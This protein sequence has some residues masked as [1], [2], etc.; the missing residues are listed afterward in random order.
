MHTTQPFSTTCTDGVTLH[1]LLLLPD[2]PK[3]VVQFNGGTATKK[4]F[5]LPF[6]EYLAGH[7]YVCC[8]WDYRG[9]GDSAPP[10]LSRCDYTFR[11]YGLQDMPAIK[12]FLRNIFP[13]L[14]L[15]LFG[16]SV[17][18]QQVGFMT[19]LE[20]IQGMVCFAVSTGYLPH[21]PLPYRLQAFYFFYLFSPISI[22]LAGYVKAKP[23][24]YMENL[25]RRVVLE[26]RDWCAKTQYLFDP[27]FY[28]RT[29]PEGNFNYTFPVHI[30][31][32]SDDPIA[33]ERSV[34][35]FWNNVSSDRGIGI[36]KLQPADFDEK[37][38][39]HFGFFKKRMAAN[40]WQMAL[41]QLD[42]FL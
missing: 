22:L 12:A 2:Q 34:P 6:L 25:P 30:F 38:I 8:L 5:Y 42:S 9:S 15:L 16:H 36:T 14:P 33:N 24:G 28:G 20:D 35:T 18:G 3:A 39:G 41:Q 27:K 1:G 7:G 29:V 10:D 11:D 13:D 40:L 4:E 19:D 17:G 32:A 37:E 31:W 23:F 21:Q 26:W